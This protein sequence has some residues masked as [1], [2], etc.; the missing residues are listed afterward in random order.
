M[1]LSFMNVDILV[2]CASPKYAHYNRPRLN[3]IDTHTL[4]FRNI[5]ERPTQNFFCRLLEHHVKVFI[6]KWLVL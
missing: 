6:N 5:H 4:I 2:R 3:A 1:S